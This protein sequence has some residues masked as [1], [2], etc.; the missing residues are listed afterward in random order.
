M[1]EYD[2]KIIREFNYE[3]AK[4]GEPVCTMDGKP[5]RIVC[6]DKK[7]TDFPIIGLVDDNGVEYYKAY[8]KDGK[9]DPTGD[10]KYNLRMKGKKQIRY[11]GVCIND[12]GER[13]LGCLYDNA[14]A[15]I[16]DSRCN[17]YI[18]LAKV[19]WEE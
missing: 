3:M 15:V 8:N 7:G 4:K 13:T 2:L 5:V 18:A 10:S 19:E 9:F 17:V 16:E 6:W 11:A 12:E 14:M 1:E